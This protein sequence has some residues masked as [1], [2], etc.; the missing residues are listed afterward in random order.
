MTMPVEGAAAVLKIDGDEPPQ[1]IIEAHRALMAETDD[2]ER[3]LELH[4]AKLALLKQ[5]RS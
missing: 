4:A 1:A 2:P 5:H 3:A